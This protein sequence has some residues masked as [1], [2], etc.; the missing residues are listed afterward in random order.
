MY[1]LRKGESIGMFLAYYCLW[2]ILNGR[3]TWEIALIGLPVAGAVW[4]FALKTLDL[5]PK[6]EMRLLRSFPRIITYIA[7]LLREVI[8]SALRVMKLIWRPGKVR[9]QL[10]RFTPDLRTGI[11]RTVLADSI[12]LTPGTITVYLEDGSLT[13]HALDVSTGEGVD[14][15]DNSMTKHVSRLEREQQ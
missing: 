3:L 1:I 4:F 2:L 10:I 9:P 7:Y 13:V 6:R 12:T 11:G 5:T 14:D 8:H 15:P